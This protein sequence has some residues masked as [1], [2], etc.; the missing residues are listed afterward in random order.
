MSV[1][2]VGYRMLLVASFGADSASGARQW[3]ELATVADLDAAVASLAGTFRVDLPEPVGDNRAVEV[4]V[5]RLADF[6][7]VGIAK[8]CPLLRRIFE[9]A[10]LCEE[11]GRSG[12]SPTTLAARLGGTYGD[13]PLDLSLAAAEASS[14]PAPPATPRET[15]TIDAILGMV[16]DSAPAS[17][18]SS[19][20]SPAAS[21]IVIWKAHLAA[22]ASAVLGAILADPGFRA[23]E[24]AW[25]GVRRILDAADTASDLVLTLR[26]AGATALPSVLQELMASPPPAPPQLILV[27]VLLDAAPARLEIW[28]ALAEAADALLTPTLVGVSPAF[29]HLA[30]WEAFSSLGHAFRAMD[31]PGLAKWRKLAAEPGGDWLGALG[32][33]AAFR[34]PYGSDNSARVAMVAESEPLW[35]S[36]VWL[37]G[38]AVAASLARCGWPHRFE[39]GSGTVLGDLA[40]T[41]A[42]GRAMAVEALVADDRALDF[43]KVGLTL[44]C[45]K[46]GGDAA[47]FLRGVTV[48]GASLADRLFLGRVLGFFFSLRQQAHLAG[49]APEELARSL[50]WRLAKFFEE[51]GHPAPD[52]L[53]IEAEP[54]AG[55]IRLAVG[56]TPPR[57]LAPSP[58]RLEFAFVW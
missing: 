5:G 29:F 28:T 12:L 23:A 20:S 1:N 9:A 54:T 44:L 39:I 17:Q 46:A 36:P 26:S 11:A 22:L 15:G 58:G 42:H 40:V 16:A 6:K 32:I 27:D 7:P 57:G 2:E 50:R 48:A 13:L 45:G 19:A 41:V 4:A 47:F 3:P 21:A 56:L 33:R 49:E 43:A 51:T 25:R 14:S 30:D 34:A 18:A 37:F 55:G 10:A 38:E 8:N 24:A 53:T 31:E 35:G 52:D